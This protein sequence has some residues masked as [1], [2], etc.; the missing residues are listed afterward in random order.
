MSKVERLVKKAGRNPKWAPPPAFGPK[1]SK[2]KIR[3]EV[4]NARRK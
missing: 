3:G 2:Q 1:A 4:L